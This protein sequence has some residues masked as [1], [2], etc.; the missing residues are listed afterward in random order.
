MINHEKL[1]RKSA[2]SP[3]PPPHPHLR[4]PTPAPYF[5]FHHFFFNFSDPLPLRGLNYDIHS[6]IAKIYINIYC[7]KVSRI[8]TISKKTH[9]A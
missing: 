8:L 2:S 9:F 6:Y 3:S 7:F 5:C 4:R 1:N